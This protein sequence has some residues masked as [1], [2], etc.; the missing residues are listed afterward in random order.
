MV[1][2]LQWYFKSEDYVLIYKHLH[3]FMKNF[4]YSW[5]PASIIWLMEILYIFSNKYVPIDA[6]WDDK[7]LK[8]DF[9]ELTDLLV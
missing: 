3:K 5:H 7:N 8:N 1:H 9:T 2:N 4:M 6:Y